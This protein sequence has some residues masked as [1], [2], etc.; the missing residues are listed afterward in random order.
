MKYQNS[1]GN[2]DVGIIAL[3]FDGTVTEKLNFPNCGKPN[4]QDYR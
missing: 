4:M 2:I 3:D 1:R